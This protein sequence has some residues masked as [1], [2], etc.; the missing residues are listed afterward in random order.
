MS[1]YD[2]IVIG[3]GI[4]GLTFASALQKTP[5]KIALVENKSLADYSSEKKHD[6]RVSAI[7]HA[8]QTILATLG[9]WPDIKKR[10][11]AYE[12]I[13][14]WDALT[15]HK[16]DFDCTEA[17]QPYLGHII[18]NRVIQHAL[19]NQL[20]HNPSVK[21]FD[22]IA[23]IALFSNEKLHVVQL[24]N[25]EYLKTKLLVGADGA[26]SFVRNQANIPLKTWSYQQSAI[27]TTIRTE[28]PHQSTAW[29]RFLPRGPLAFLPLNDPHICS[30]V[31]STLDSHAE[32]LMR[33]ADE[34]FNLALTQAFGCRLGDITAID[35]RIKFPLHMR[36]AKQ[37]VKPNLA[38]IGDSAHTI[39]PLAG[40]GVNLG[41]LDAA[42]L[43]QVIVDALQKQRDFA[44]M[45]VLRRYERWRKGENWLMIAAMEAFKRL[46]S[47]SSSVFAHIRGKGL[48]LTDQN[49]WLKTIF[50]Q[51]AMGLSGDL[52]YA[53]KTRNTA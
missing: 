11:A 15:E 37:Y 12:H 4:V 29:Q 42:S 13:H 16:I 17:G 30:I 33:L 27:V 8:S 25:G 48:Q 18:E 1:Y 5:L 9:V 35:R 19:I 39:H 28:Y 38:L 46:F 24:Q 47:N 2:I 53:A 32:E 34:E 3:G 51:H 21:I 50:M 31:W 14:A 49:L 36:H 26:N 23:P 52:P 40:Q 45:T 43:A 22:H 10:A 7:T 44:S 41:L 20:Q 6:L